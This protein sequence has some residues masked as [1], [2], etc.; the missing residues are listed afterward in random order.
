MKIRASFNRFVKK[1]PSS[2]KN[3]RGG[4]EEDQAPISGMDDSTVEVEKKSYGMMTINA[5][6]LLSLLVFLPLFSPLYTVLHCTSLL[7]YSN[8]MVMPPTLI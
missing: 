1:Q 2:F 8:C 4:E 6:L 7:L 5:L 3:G